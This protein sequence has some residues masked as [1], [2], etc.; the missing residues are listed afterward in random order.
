MND[1]LTS[2][3]TQKSTLNWI[4]DML[5]QI[6]ITTSMQLFKFKVRYN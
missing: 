3:H 2:H 6:V 1:V 4:K 5:V